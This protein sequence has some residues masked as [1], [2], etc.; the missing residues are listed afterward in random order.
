MLA[1]PILGAVIILGFISLAI[2]FL[3]S[4][5]YNILNLMLYILIQIARLCSF[6]PFSNIKIITP[7]I[8]LVIMYYLIIMIFLNYHKLKK[9][10][11]KKIILIFLLAIV[12]IQSYILI[13]PS[14][15]K[16]YFIDVGQGDSTLIVTPNKKTILIDGG[17]SESK[18]FDVGNDVLI[19]Y[20]LDRKIYKL[21][22]I[23]ISHFDTDH[24][25]GILT[26]LNELK[27]GNVIIS[28]QY[29]DSENFAEFKKIV[30]ENNIKVIVVNKGERLR[31]EKDINIEI[32]WPNNEE[33]LK[34]NSLNNNSIVCKLNYKS[35]SMLFTGD[36]E[37]IAEK[38][39]LKE[40]E[41]SLELLD[42]TILKVGHHGSKTSST[43]YFIEAVKPDIALIGVGENNKFDHPNG[44]VLE[45]LK[46][47]GT[48]IYRTDQMGEITLE[49]DKNGNIKIKKHVK[50]ENV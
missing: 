17:G 7:D 34:E 45:R 39:I 30:N 12:L 10:I 20:L 27:V 22:Y 26:V 8:F 47:Y 38:Q 18:N 29:K 40:Y 4:F 3:P 41:N 5:Y 15:L 16:I 35:F 44:N 28:K 50:Q 11:K 19:P 36:I 43:Q 49:I 14:D 1:T 2:P 21:D 23:L 46:R 33:L 32:L 9:Y 6:L 13:V 24:V 48:K 25:G 42:S 31:I 37:E